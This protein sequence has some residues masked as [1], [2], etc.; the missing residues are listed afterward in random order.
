MQS[1]IFQTKS[2]R[3]LSK[4]LGE[5]NEYQVADAYIEGKD[6]IRGWFQSSL[7]LSY[8]CEKKLPYKIII[9]HGFVVDEYGSKMSKSKGN[10]V[11]LH[12]TI[13]KFGV[14]ILRIWVMSS[15]YT[16]DVAIGPKIIEKMCEN[17]RKIRNVIRYL[18]SVVEAEKMIEG[19]NDF[20]FLEKAMLNELQEM[21]NDYKSNLEEFNLRKA[22]NNIYLFINRVSELYFNAIKDTLYCDDIENKSRISVVQFCFILLRSLNILLTPLLPFTTEEIFQYCKERSIS[23]S[24][25]RSIHE[26]SINDIKIRAFS[27]EYEI[28]S[29]EKDIEILR[30]KIEKIKQEGLCN[31]NSDLY[32]NDN[33]EFKNCSNDIALLKKQSLVKILGI[34]GFKK[35]NHDLEISDLANCVRCS[36]KLGSI[37]NRCNLILNT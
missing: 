27:S 29:M 35:I 24:E 22:F 31:R 28:K 1:Q 5:K 26:Y 13:D 7:L 8:L 16:D 3:V 25:N 20:E 21:I 32:M 37:C 30:Q 19:F 10:V 4:Y 2:S 14:E 18:I 23:I 36:K 6:Q 12:E 15:D 34:L 33:L 17:Y 11:D 9:S